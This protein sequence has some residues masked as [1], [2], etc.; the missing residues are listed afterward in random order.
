MDYQHRNWVNVTTSYPKQA[1][2][3]SMK[4]HFLEVRC[5]DTLWVTMLVIHTDLSRTYGESPA[6]MISE[7]LIATINMGESKKICVYLS[8]RSVSSL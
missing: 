7:G 5:A 6:T 3:T 2:K 1:E 4:R 8:R